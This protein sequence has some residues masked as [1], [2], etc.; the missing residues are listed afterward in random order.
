MTLSPLP[1]TT[2]V[3]RASLYVDN[4]VVLPVPTVHDLTCFQ[5]ILPLFAEASGLVM[6]LDKYAIT[7][8]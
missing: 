3:H 8:I 6:N 7:P 4:L 5:Q 1:C 2:I